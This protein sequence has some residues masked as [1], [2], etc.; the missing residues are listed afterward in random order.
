MPKPSK[1]LVENVMIKSA[2]ALYPSVNF[3]VEGRMCESWAEKDWS[4]LAH[5]LFGSVDFRH[6]D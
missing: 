2:V 5:L 4:S 1:K 6:L 3:E